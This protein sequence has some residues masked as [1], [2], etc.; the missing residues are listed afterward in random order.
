MPIKS[1][2]LTDM[3]DLTGYLARLCEILEIVIVDGSDEPVFQAHAS[4]WSRLALHIAPHP[5]IRGLNGKVRGVLSGLR[6]IST[7]KVIIADDDVRYDQASLSAVID[8]LHCCDVVRPQNYFAPHVWHTLLDSGRTLLNRVSGGDWPG[9]LGVR[10]NAI[11]NGYNADVLFENFQ[12]IETVKARGG[13]EHIAYDIFVARKPPSTGHF[14]SQ[15][16]RQAYDEFARPVRLCVSLAIVPL[17]LAALFTGRTRPALGLAL[18]C[19]ATAEAGRQRANATRHF[20]LLASFV[21]PL[22][23]LERGICVWIALGLRVFRGGVPYAGSV[24]RDA[25]AP[26]R[27]GKGEAA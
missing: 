8:A 3:Q 16:I 9:T 26:V 17:F 14:F 5:S 25:A 22:W 19:I 4:A 11:V 20:P 1:A 2:A 23:V 15:R 13:R 18:A 10:R 27:K 12:L 21:A 6:C 24:I 7:E